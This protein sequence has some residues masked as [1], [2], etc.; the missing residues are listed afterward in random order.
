MFR[1]G[2]NAF[3][4]FHFVSLK[5]TGI[6]LEKV[7]YYDSNGKLQQYIALGD[8]ACSPTSLFVIVDA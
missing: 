5:A 4:C 1:G 3:K 7:H 8:R 2:T 6:Q